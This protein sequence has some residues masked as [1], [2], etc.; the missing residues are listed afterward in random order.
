MRGIMIISVS[1]LLKVLLLV[2]CVVQAG[3]LVASS[4]LHR[5]EDAITKLKDLL[6]T[7]PQEKLKQFDNE[8]RAEGA[9]LEQEWSNAKTWLGADVN[10]KVAVFDKQ[11]EA[12]LVQL[13]KD[14]SHVKSLLK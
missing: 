2:N 8:A 12:A 3:T 7:E 14:Q 1:K 5:I 11:S 4:R 6:K 10:Q 13:T 9:R